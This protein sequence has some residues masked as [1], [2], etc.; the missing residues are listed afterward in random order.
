MYELLASFFTRILG[1]DVQIQKIDEN[2]FIITGKQLGDLTYQEN[3]VSNLLESYGL[4]NVI[5]LKAGTKD[6]D[7]SLIID[8]SAKW[9]DKIERYTGKFL[10]PHIEHW[11]TSDLNR[12][13]SYIESTGLWNSKSKLAS[14]LLLL[15][16]FYPKKKLSRIFANISQG[17]MS[18]L[19]TYREGKSSTV[20]QKID[21][22]IQLKSLGFNANTVK[23][24]NVPLF[25]FFQ[26]FNAKEVN[27]EFNSEGVELDSQ[28]FP[29]ERMKQL[30]D[31]SKFTGSTSN[32]NAKL[33]SLYK[34]YKQVK[35]CLE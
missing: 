1:Y 19:L 6:K 27:L 12:Y 18:Q 4:N 17:R 26:S 9:Q 23:D 21:G 11:N 10:P 15:Y 28:F 24:L 3:Y 14:H 32:Q 29:E 20:F 25:N 35:T 22:E 30:I 7:P 5:T 13:A 16:N 34:V 33:S 2:T 8:F 31:I